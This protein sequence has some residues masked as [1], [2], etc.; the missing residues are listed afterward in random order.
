[1]ALIRARDL[2]H[3]AFNLCCE[4]SVVSDRRGSMLQFTRHFLVFLTQC[5]DPVMIAISGAA[6]ESYEEFEGRCRRIR[7]IL[8]LSDSFRGDTPT[9]ASHF[10]NNHPGDI[11]KGDSATSQDDRVFIAFTLKEVRTTV[12]TRSFSGLPRG[13]SDRL[14]SL[15]RALVAPRIPWPS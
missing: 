12:S 14:C 13:S 8:E 15:S 10:S 4:L 5:D 2:T 9:N 7:D 1:M 3:R 11:L 6:A